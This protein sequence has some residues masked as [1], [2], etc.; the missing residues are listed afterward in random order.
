MQLNEKEKGLGNVIVAAKIKFD[1]EDQLVIESYGHQY[2]QLS[3]VRK[4]K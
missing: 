2:V 3:N 4:H 1:D